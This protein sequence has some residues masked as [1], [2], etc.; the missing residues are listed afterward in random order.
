M[1]HSKS[2]SVYNTRLQASLRL[3][4]RINHPFFQ[5]IFI[6]TVGKNPPAYAG[7]TI[8]SLPWED[9]TCLGATKPMGHN[10]WA[11]MLQ[12]LKPTHIEPMLHHK[13]RHR[14]EKSAHC[15]KE[16]TQL[17]AAREN[18]TKQWRPSTTENKINEKKN[19]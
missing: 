10:Y 3:G 9:S 7:D 18:R 1:I 16:A 13:R 8:L 19:F 2:V 4:S 17:T 15:S 14:N 6:G 5:N 11:Y 12:P